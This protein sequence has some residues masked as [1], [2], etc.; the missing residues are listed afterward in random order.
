MAF[1]S[2]CTLQPPQMGSILNAPEIP[3]QN[4]APRAVLTQTCPWT[5]RDA[6]QRGN[7]NLRPKESNPAREFPGCAG[8]SN[9]RKT[10]HPLP[11][12]IKGQDNEQHMLRPMKE[13]SCA[14]IYPSTADLLPLVTSICSHRHQREAKERGTD[15]WGEVSVS[16]HYKLGLSPPGR[17]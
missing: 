11:Y 15:P 12:S 13:I 6:P 10:C 5:S 9:P 3:A 7:P 14:G 16:H 1:L 17:T 8:P 4:R 2:A